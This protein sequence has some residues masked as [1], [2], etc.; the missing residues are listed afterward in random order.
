MES[1]PCF[2][3]SFFAVLKIKKIQKAKFDFSPDS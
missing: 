3:F 2:E 1:A